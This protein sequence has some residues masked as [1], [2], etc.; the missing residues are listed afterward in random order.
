MLVQA[1]I[2]VGELIDKITILE[3]KLDR[4]N[5]ANKLANIALELG[6]LSEI[7][8]SLELKDAESLLRADLKE[9]NAALWDIE[10]FKRGC[11]STRDF[12]PA[13]IEASR[14]VYLKNDQRAALK[15]AINVLAGSTIIEE[16]SY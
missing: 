4:I 15:R 2:S 12:G 13:F 16:K 11:E 14:D 8:A 6:H 5:D 9:I 1:P 7:L 10:N 3:I